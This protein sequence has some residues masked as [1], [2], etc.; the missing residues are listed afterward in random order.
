MTNLSNYYIFYLN[1]LEYCPEGH[2]LILVYLGNKILI[3][4]ENTKKQYSHIILIILV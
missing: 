2:Y 4:R 3:W 1:L